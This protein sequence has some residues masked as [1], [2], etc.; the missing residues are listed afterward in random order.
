MNLAV[1]EA[2]MSFN[3]IIDRAKWFMKKEG[4]LYPALYFVNK[5]RPTD[6]VGVYKHPN[7]VAEDTNDDQLPESS[8]IYYTGMAVKIQSDEDDDMVQVILNDIV[9]KH[10]PDAA[11]IT[12]TCSYNKIKPSDK[13]SFE[14]LH[15]LP[16]TIR[17]LHACFY[18]R[19]PKM[20]VSK[21][22]PFINYGINPLVPKQTPEEA[23]PFAMPF[24]DYG[25]ITDL[26]T[27]KPRI[28]DPYKR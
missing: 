23:G 3:R 25:W 26:E 17:V 16:D 4:Y 19:E 24:V 28:E 21:M 5:G 1:H 22:I 15:L 18:L 27:Y 20:G 12:L 11:G 2:T 8:D 13:K 7:I 14:N 9:R 10:N 6:I